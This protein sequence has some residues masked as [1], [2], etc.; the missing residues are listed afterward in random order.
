MKATEETVVNEETGEMQVNQN[1]LALAQSYD[2][3]AVDSS[4]QFIHLR[5]NCAAAGG[6]FLIGDSIFAKEVKCSLIAVKSI[7]NAAFF[8]KSGEIPKYQDWAQIL[9]VDEK[10]KNLKSTLVKTRSIAGIVGL[11]QSAMAKGNSPVG[12]SFTMRFA[13]ASGKNE[14]GESFSY[15]YVQFEQ[16]EEES[17]VKQMALDARAAIDSGELLFPEIQSN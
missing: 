16:N 2:M 9:F 13:D 12:V 17:P 15:K 10:Y 3:V 5:P 6:V 8:T 1:A 11:V 4:K 14:K 7:R